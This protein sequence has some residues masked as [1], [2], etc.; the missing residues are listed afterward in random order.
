MLTRSTWRCLVTVGDLVK[1]IMQ[2]G[3][4]PIT[5]VIIK[6]WHDRSE[7]VYEVRNV[8]S[9]LKTHAGESN[10]ELISESR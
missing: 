1:V 8:K 10:M 2:W 3:Q 6:K 7:W 5:G 4:P 9:G